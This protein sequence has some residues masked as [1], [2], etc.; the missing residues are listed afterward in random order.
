MIYTGKGADH[1]LAVDEILDVLE[2]HELWLKPEKCEFSKSEVEYLGLIISH[3]KIKMDPTKVKAVSDWPAPR[4]VSEL[5]R[6]IGF[7]NF[8]RRFIDQF[9]R[10]TRPLHNLTKLKA[11]FLWD[12]K[13]E[14]SFTILK[15]AFTSA[16]VLKIADP[17]KA[18]ILE[19]DCSDFALGAIL[20]QR[21]EEDNEIHPV[22]YLSRSLAQ[23]ERNYE[24]FDKE[25]LAIVA[26]FKEWRHYLEGNPNR[27]DVIVYTDH[28]NLESFMT[29]KQLTRRQARW[30]ET[31]GCF[32]FTIRFRPGQQG[33]KPDAL[34]RRPDLAPH[35]DDKLTFGQLIRP[36]NLVEDSF[37][38]IDCLESWF[39]DEN[40]DLNDAERWFEVDVLGIDEVDIGEDTEV[41]EEPI[42][43]DNIIIDKIREVT[44]D[45][46]R[47]MEIIEAVE[48]PISTKMKAAMSRFKFSDG[49]VY[50]NN[51]IEVPDNKEIKH[52]I[53][54]SR[55]DGVLIGHPGRSKT[56]G[57]VR[58]CF[59]WPSMKSYVNKYVDG[60]DSCLRVKSSSLK[61]YG[62]LEPFPIPAGP[63]T[64]ISYDL[65]TKLPLSNGKDSILTVVD[66]LTKMAH[67]IP[68]Q[69]SMSS[70]EL[71]D[72][73]VKEV[74]RLHGTPKTI[75]SDRGG[76]FI[77]Q[78]MKEL[79]RR[80]G[81]RISP[82]TAFH[83]RTNGQSEIVNKSIEGYLRHFVSYRQDDW[84]YFIPTAEFAYN[85]RDHS[86]TGISPFKA[87]FG[88]DANFG[89]I[90]LKE[91]CIPL[92][93]ERLK[94]L[95]KVQEELKE[96]LEMSQEE[97]KI[98][99]DKSVRSTPEWNIGDQVWLN[100]KNITT[101]RPSPKLDHR[102][103]GPFTISKRVSRSTYKLNLPLSMKGIH[104]V[105]HVSLLRKHKVDEIEERQIKEPSQIFIEGNEEWEVA[106]ILDCR[107]RFKKIEYLVSWKGFSTE[108]NSWEPAENLKN[109]KQL[110][111]EFNARF[112]NISEKYKRRRRK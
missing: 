78:T 8:Y 26:S 66:R 1:E 104:P 34:S 86:S 9:S 33:S 6:F 39:E 5:Q 58:R 68:C 83:P 15:A 14:E 46:P 10:I 41:S 82:S 97:M 77:S 7:A 13:C 93:E 24:I 28:R 48:N 37:V 38:K 18:F 4:T 91:Q 102:W 32:D 40:I 100:N 109:S 35:D 53:L 63:W 50:Q 107:K 88:Y 16:P 19:C 64:D 106:E 111:N 67:F 11:Q 90:P 112:P 57:L 25:L 44:K 36:E 85:N 70:E 92:V 96:C 95:E 49:I 110:V 47:L 103:L 62:G 45:C 23:A 99:F 84:E 69:E 108:H 55:H 61:P 30:A 73:M 29:T 27:L 60:C 71:A 89:G 80:L 20:S 65:I 75:V 54:R 42:Y 17:Y 12:D 3:N 31:L 43:N 79:N 74:W 2:K 21:C 76:V 81:I 87:N 22:A 56:L 98:Q 105:F 94:L 52:M 101:T 72:I 59:T 51:R